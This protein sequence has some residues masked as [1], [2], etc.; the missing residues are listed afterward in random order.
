MES[1]ENKRYVMAA[2]AKTNSKT[3]SDFHKAFM[4]KVW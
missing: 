1:L 3:Y 2:N 4:N